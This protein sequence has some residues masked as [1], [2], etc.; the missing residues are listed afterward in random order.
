MQRSSAASPAD[1]PHSGTA[2]EPTGPRTSSSCGALRHVEHAAELAGD[3]RIERRIRAL[4]DQDRH[5]RR[6]GAKARMGEV[7]VSDVQRCTPATL[8]AFAICWS[9]FR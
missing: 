8:R 1:G 6:R 7:F 9:F 2:P 3:A 5:G 4:V